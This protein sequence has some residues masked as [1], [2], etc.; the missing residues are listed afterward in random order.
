MTASANPA[1]LGQS[2]TLTAVASDEV[3]SG[4]PT[5]S[6]TFEDGTTVLGTVN[7]DGTGT[8]T[9]TTATL[10]AGSHTLTALYDGDA[11][12]LPSQSSPLYEGINQEASTTTLTPSAS[13]AVFGQPIVFTATVGPTFSG[14][15]APT[16]TVTFYEGQ[17]VLGTAAL[18]GG[19][20]TFT[21]A[22]LAVGTYTNNI[23]ASYGGDTN[24]TSSYLTLPSL[25]V[26]PDTTS[27][28]LKR[29]AQFVEARAIGRVDGHGLGR[30]S[31]RGDSRRLGD[32]H[33]R[34]E[35]SGHCPTRWFGRCDLRDQ[36][37]CARHSQSDR[38]VRGHDGRRRQHLECHQL[39]GEQ[40]H[41]HP[42]R[43]AQ[44]LGCRAVAAPHGHRLLQFR[45]PDRHGDLP[46]R[47]HAAGHRHAQRQRRR[48]V[49][50]HCPPRRKPQSHGGL[51]RATG[52]TFVAST[53]N[54]LV[55][56]VKVAAS[57]VAL[58]AAPSPSTFGQS[59][60]WT[61]TVSGVISGPEPTGTVTFEDG[62]TV[63]GTG[64]IA[65]DKATFTS[66]ALS[67]GS[68]SI[69]AIYNGD[70]NYDT[71]TS[72]AATQSVTAASSS[73]VVTSSLTPWRSGN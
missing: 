72:T 42:E 18:S 17:T 55:Q 46:G 29:L 67:I 35:C 68:H 3:G 27:T 28:A 51:Q 22:S 36:L 24:Y 40:H 49:Q 59:V 56:T 37:A 71:S 58:A 2:L 73:T 44:S 1:N 65:S 16:G 34:H 4:T 66:S 50:H 30:Q 38:R 31:R 21:D 20:A 19:T 64:T 8:A 13:P 32:L 61:A 23:T 60:T 11:N 12:Y 33:G 6:I 69:T 15:P 9:L 62:S 14:I 7:L 47:Q 52:S 39:R 48:D 45:N 26:N 10:L 70:T 43:I 53:S 41:H 54:T 5:G 57:T 63:L 25:T